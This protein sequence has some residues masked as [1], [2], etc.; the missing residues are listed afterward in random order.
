MARQNAKRLRTDEWM[1][2]FEGR[3]LVEHELV[4]PHKT[5]PT[6]TADMSLGWVDSGTLD[7]PDS[8]AVQLNSVAVDCLSGGT[9][10]V[11]RSARVNWVNNT[12]KTKREKKQQT[13]KM[14]N[15]IIYQNFLCNV[16]KTKEPTDQTLPLNLEEDFDCPVCF[17]Y[18]CRPLKIFSC[19]NGHFICS[20]CVSNPKIKL[21]PICRDDFN[22]RKPKRCL[23]TE[24]QAENCK[25]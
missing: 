10:W 24:K 15:K 19:Y 20:V 1:T 23:E 14:E 8:A 21:C 6:R 18:M 7:V 5:L 4:S 17:E 2:D 13:I 22:Q 16:L 9:N 25:E 12:A 3:N 11:L